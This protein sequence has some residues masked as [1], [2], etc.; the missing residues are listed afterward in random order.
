VGQLD[1]DAV[2]YL[3]TRGI[4]AQEATRM[5]TRAFAGEIIERVHVEALRQDLD[6]LIGQRL[7]KELAR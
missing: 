1:E 3:R 5:L 2:F 7:E 4:D 6:R